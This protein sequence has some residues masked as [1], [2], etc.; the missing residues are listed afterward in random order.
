MS[1]LA[2]VIAIT[3]SVTACLGS[4]FADSVEGA[5]EL[6]SGTHQGETVPILGSHP[7]TMTLEDGEIGGTA[8]CNSY[9]G[10]YRISGNS[11]EIEDGLAVTEMACQPQE[12]MESERRF[13]EALVAV[14][15]VE[16]GDQE[17]L[18]RSEATELQ[19]TLLPPVP[20]ADLLG[21]TW[22]LEAL[23]QGD[24]VSS[25]MTQAEPATLELSPDGTFTGSTGCRTISGIYQIT[26]AEVQFTEFSAE[27]ECPEE[28]TEQDS[29]VISALEGGFR[30]EID[31]EQMTTWVAGDERLV[32]RSES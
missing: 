13:L 31:G 28:L 12:V 8:A 2:L 17:L 14:D 32:Y 23:V 9:G 16:L 11:F 3:L 26:G 4:D 21:T 6:R 7:I 5:W 25:P 29:R 27:G 15:T 30:V 18:L 24:A 20:T 10:R 19:F 1:R 22:V